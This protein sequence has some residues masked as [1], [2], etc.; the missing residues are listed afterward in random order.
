MTGAGRLSSDPQPVTA[1]TAPL[2]L[3]CIV[4]RRS[5]TKFRASRSFCQDGSLKGENP[6]QAGFFRA[7]RQP[8]PAGTRQAIGGLISKTRR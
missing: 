2:F 7:S 8:G 5:L 4:C 3:S 1:Y 6:A